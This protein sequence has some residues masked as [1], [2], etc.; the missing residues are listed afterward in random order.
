MSSE[1]CRAT[2]AYPWRLYYDA[3]G[4]LHRADGPAVDLIPGLDPEAVELLED[5]VF[6]WRMHGIW[7]RIDGPAMMGID[8]SRQWWVDGKQH[9]IDGPAVERPDGTREWW[10]DGKRHRL[11]GPA[12]EREGGYRE[13]WIDGIRQRDPRT[14]TSAP[15]SSRS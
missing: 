1:P 9:R 14:G 11:D 12:V 13:W 2:D 4:R 15:D 6:E 8:G 7:H 3:D 10:A 5:G